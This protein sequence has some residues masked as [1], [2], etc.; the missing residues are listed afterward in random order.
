MCAKKLFGSFRLANN[1]LVYY[2]D[3]VLLMLSL[4]Q[5]CDSTMST[6]QQLFLSFPLNGTNMYYLYVPTTYVHLGL[7]VVYPSFEE[8]FTNFIIVIL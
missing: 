5:N 8:L 2:N 7:V 6:P 1:V 3:D 4:S